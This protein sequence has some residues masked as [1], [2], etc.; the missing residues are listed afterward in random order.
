MS[1]TCGPARVLTLLPV[2][3]MLKYEFVVVAVWVWVTVWVMYVVMT[4]G[5]SQ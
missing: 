2:A 5:I 3:R 4:Y 1:R